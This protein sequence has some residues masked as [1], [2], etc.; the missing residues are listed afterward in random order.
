MIEKIKEYPASILVDSHDDVYFEKRGVQMILDLEIIGRICEE[1]EDQDKVKSILE[2][3]DL[4][5]L[6]EWKQELAENFL[7]GF[8][9]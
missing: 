9:K 4:P 2:S 3:K 5:I 6:N 8:H 7:K 1:N